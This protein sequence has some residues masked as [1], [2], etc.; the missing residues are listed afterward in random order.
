MQKLREHVNVITKVIIDNGGVGQMS[1]KNNILLSAVAALT[2]IV[3][4]IIIKLNHK[5]L[6]QSS[7]EGASLNLVAQKLLSLSDK[8]L[9]MFSAYGLLFLLI[10]FLFVK[11]CKIS[12]TVNILFLSIMSTLFVVYVLFVFMYL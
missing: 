6:Y 3:P 12:K 9:Y 10:T 7:I 2:M 1:K 4:L 8:S 11:N 5:I